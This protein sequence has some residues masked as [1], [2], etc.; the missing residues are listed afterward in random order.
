MPPSG[1]TARSLSRG[2]RVATPPPKS[3]RADDRIIRW[4]DRLDKPIQAIAARL[5]VSVV[6]SAAWVDDAYYVERGPSYLAAMFGVSV[7]EATA[8]HAGILTGLMTAV[9]SAPLDPRTRRDRQLVEA[10]SE[11]G[12]VRRGRQATWWRLSEKG[13]A[14]LTALGVHARAQGYAV[15]SIRVGAAIALDVRARLG[16]QLRAVCPLHEDF[17]TRSLRLSRGGGVYCYTCCRSIGRWRKTPEGYRL[18]PYLQD[19]PPP[20]AADWS[21]EVVRLAGSPVQERP[22]WR[23]VQRID[24]HGRRDD[25]T[26]WDSSTAPREQ[27]HV[28]RRVAPDRLKTD[29]APCPD[30]LGQ[31]VRMET[32]SAREDAQIKAQTLYETWRTAGEI[33]GRLRWR[34]PQ[35]TL[36]CGVYAHRALR[37]GSTTEHDGVEITI[38]HPQHFSRVVSSRWIGLSVKGPA[39]VDEQV[40]QRAARA[41]QG[42]VRGARWAGVLSGRIGLVHASPGSVALAVEMDASRAN[43]RGFFESADVQAMVV[44]LSGL[45]E[46]A[47]HAAGWACQTPEVVPHVAAPGWRVAGDVPFRSR[48]IWASVERPAWWPDYLAALER[49]RANRRAQDQARRE[50]RRR[51]LAQSE[52]RDT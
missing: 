32:S 19:D 33:P 14:A 35:P 39:G 31:L 20:P 15:P 5:V 24:V 37:A 48:L 18:W 34:L 7:V 41:L 22:D 17:Y 26:T 44:E 38:S 36:S 10:L 43:P 3:I 16:G 50:R 25:G 49:Q 6:R 1:A 11:A 40:L 52:D 28:L 27:G 47:M 4:F 51:A 29:Y 42:Q 9:R 2:R 21:P 45:V 8:H 46:Q 13:H 12:L 30:L 23:P